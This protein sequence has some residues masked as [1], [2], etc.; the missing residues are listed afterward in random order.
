MQRAGA[1]AAGPAHRVEPLAD[2]VLVGVAQRED[3]VRE[4]VLEQGFQGE[5]QRYAA[6]AAFQAGDGGAGHAHAAGQRGLRF[7]AAQPGGADVGADARERF[8]GVE[9]GFELLFHDSII[10]LYS[11]NCTINES[12]IDLDMNH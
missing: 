3:L 9:T 7:G 10:V 4:P 12:W 8:S 2:A 1:A 5:R 11:I 6:V